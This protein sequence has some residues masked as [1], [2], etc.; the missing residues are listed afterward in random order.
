MTTSERGFDD[1]VGPQKGAKCIFPMKL[2]GKTYN[3]C[4]PD[5]KSCDWCSTKGT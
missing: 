2:G 4:V 3:R 5:D 1:F